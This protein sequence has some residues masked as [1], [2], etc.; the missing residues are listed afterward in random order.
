M[1]DRPIAG[2]ECALY[3]KNGAAWVEIKNAKDVSLPDS[4]E[5]IDVSARYSPAKKYIAGMSDG[6][7]EFGYQYIKGTDTVFDALQDHY[8]TREPIEVAAADGDITTTGTVYSRDWYVITK[9]ERTEE[10]GGSRV[11]SVTLQPT[12]IFESGAIVER[13]FHVVSGGGG[14]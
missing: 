14:S 5:A 1:S 6:S 7:I 8:L 11:Y 12:V 2:F 3:Y 9:F 4:T 13:S 10:L